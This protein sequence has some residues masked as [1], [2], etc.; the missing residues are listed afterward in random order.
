MGPGL[1]WEVSFFV[2]FCISF[3][4]SIGCMGTMGGWVVFFVRFLYCYITTCRSGNSVRILC[5]GRD[6]VVVGDGDGDPFTM[7]FGR[8]DRQGTSGFNSR[9]GQTWHF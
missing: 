3:L 9:S 1:G 8:T 7:V 6:G 2:L 4:P 5:G